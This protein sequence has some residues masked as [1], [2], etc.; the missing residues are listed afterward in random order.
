MKSKR[1]KY[2]Y[3]SNL[4]Y[5]G[6]VYQTQVLDW[7]KLYEEHN[8]KFDLIQVFHIKDLKRPSYI[9]SQMKGLRSSS[10]YFSGS[11]Y[12]FPSKSVLYLFN[13]FFLFL[14]IFWSLSRNDE[15]VIF[16]RAIIGREIFLLKKFYPAKLKYIFDARAAAAEEN[17][18]LAASRNDFSRRRYRI[19]A[20]T[21]YLVYQ[22]LKA[23][24]KVFVVS[25]VLKDYFIS[26]YNLSEKNFVLY[27]CLSDSGKFSFNESIRDEQRKELGIGKSKTT[28]IYSGG[29]DEWHIASKMFEFFRHLKKHRPDI[30]I[31]ILTR[32]TEGVDKMLERYQE[33]KPNVWHTSVNNN[34]VFKYLNAADYGVLFRENTL[35]N[36]VASP[37]K[38]AE[39]MLC[40][41][42]V[43]I[44][45]GVG[46]FSEYAIDNDLGVLI[47][48]SELEEPGS[49]DFASFLN[50][51]FDRKH[52]AQVGKDNFSKT[53][54]IDNITM[55]LM[56]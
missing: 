22:T 52:I 25:N 29:I 37:T 16:S 56:I 47:K 31:I 38:F 34:E 24:D 53:S 30:I 14:K 45:E 39:Y 35:M 48:E 5:S 9:R 17:K 12:L 49:F 54:L 15:V 26:T 28:F 21:Y 27:P 46:D 36:N 20:N 33:I 10:D 23:A 11:I 19:I 51:K 7:L 13:S 4:N 32:N 8:L 43:I 42:P 2:I 1:R 50:R 3:L 55:E 6:S 44:S 41:L 18:Y 40:G